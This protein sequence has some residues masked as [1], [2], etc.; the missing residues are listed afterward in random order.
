MYGMNGA[1]QY[2]V[3]QAIIISLDYVNQLYLEPEVIDDIALTAWRAS[4]NERR[5]KVTV[6]ALREGQ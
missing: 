6:Q 1:Y 4:S 5:W 2:L 3:A